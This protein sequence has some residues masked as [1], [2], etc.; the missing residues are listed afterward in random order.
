MSSASRKCGLHRNAQAQATLEAAFA[1]PVIMVGL[2]LL[3]Q[4]G[5]ILY[6]RIVMESAAADGCR[7]LSTLARED[8]IFDDY[9]RRRLSAI[10]E[11]DIFHVH[12][13]GCSWVIEPSGNEASDK[14][15]VRMSTQLKPLPLLDAGMSLVGLTNSNGNL[16]VNV[17][18]SM[19]P[20]PSWV[21]ET[22]DGRDPNG[23]CDWDLRSR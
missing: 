5:I 11:M 2:L 18:E 20:V 3:L 23:W 7:L 17:E 1:I 22:E 8:G 12:S 19:T 15:S 6:D 9:M 10:P 14:V 4:P 21:S 13:G 16:E